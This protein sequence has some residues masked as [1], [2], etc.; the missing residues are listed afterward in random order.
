[1]LID[2]IIAQLRQFTP[3]LKTVG[4]AADFSAGLET[5]ANPED[6]PS[7]WVI[8]LADS[9]SENDVMN[10]LFQ[11]VQERISVV[12]EFDNSTDRRGQA[13][14]SQV[15]GMK[16]AIF[17]SLLNWRNDPARAAKG[18]QYAGGCLLGMDRGRIWWTFDFSLDVTIDDDDGFQEPAVD[19]V[20]IDVDVYLEGFPEQPVE[21]VP[22]VPV[23]IKVHPPY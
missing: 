3:E 23:H 2:P 12:V 18:L 16:Y 1:M 15:E 20:E 5:V 8:P 17:R 19:L 13:A 7:G 6:L 22:E 11:S 4:G 21:P 14:V 10:G 9:S